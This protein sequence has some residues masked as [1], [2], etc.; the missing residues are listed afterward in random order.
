MA[1]IILWLGLVLTAQAGPADPDPVTMKQPDGSF[2]TV[3]LHGDEFCHWMTDDLGREVVVGKDGRLVFPDADIP[4]LAKR[5]SDGGAL[6]AEAAAAGHSLVAPHDGEIHF[7][8]ILL[9][10]QDVGFTLSRP[11]ES[12]DTHFNRDVRDYFSEGSSGLF[13]PVFD[14]YGPVT[15]PQNLSHYGGNTLGQTDRNSKYAFLNACRL[16]AEHGLDFSKYDYDCDGYVDEVMFI[17]AGYAESHGG[18]PDA[19]WPHFASLDSRLDHSSTDNVFGSVKVDAYGCCPELNGNYGAN[20]CGIGLICHEFCHSIGLPD[21]Y[22]TDYSTNGLSEHMSRF[23]VMGTGNNNSSCKN[24]PYLCAIERYLLGWS[25]LPEP[26][27]DDIVVLDGIQTGKACRINTDNPGEFFILE[28][29]NLKG[30]DADIGAGGLLIYHVDMSSNSVGTVTAEYM[31]DNWHDIN[32]INAYASHP[33]CSPV[34]SSPT[35][36]ITARVFPGSDS[37]TSARLVSWSGAQVYDMVTDIAFTGDKVIFH[38]NGP[39]YKAGIN[40]IYNPGEGSYSSGYS[41]GLTLV[42]RR[43]PSAVDWYLDGIPAGG[44]SVT[45]ESGEHVVTAVLHFAE[46]DEILEQFLKVK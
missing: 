45:L 3:H 35:S 37:V 28:C 34:A 20:I 23:S 43:D 25:D 6:R 14:I 17:Y 30:R 4:S 40:A 46:G 8:V 1:G 11:A 18:G 31:W 19:I 33:C 26:V 44:A 5:F 27:S 22:D 16:A 13:T 41:F 15:L 10:F 24:P 21:L 2:V 32:E 7:P 42:G 9:E 38:H 29:R 36:G 39:L 12:F